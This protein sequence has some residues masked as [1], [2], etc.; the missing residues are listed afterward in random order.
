MNS[1]SL[2]DCFLCLDIFGA[3]EYLEVNGVRF[4]PLMPPLYIILLVLTSS[5]FVD[6]LFA[7]VPYV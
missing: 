4:M 1:N 5:F 7:S 2:V 3:C 6:R